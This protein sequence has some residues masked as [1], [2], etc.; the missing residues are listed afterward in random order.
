MKN[1]S[2]I[3]A[4]L[5][6]L[7]LTACGNNGTDKEKLK[8]ELKEEPKKEMQVESNNAQNQET[9]TSDFEWEGT[10]KYKDQTVT[11]KPD[12]AIESTGDFPYNR[13]M[14]QEKNNCGIDIIGLVYMGIV[15]FHYKRKGN[16]IELYHMEM[17]DCKVKELF[18]ILEKQ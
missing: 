14:V 16:K 5:L 10:Y 18:A 3:T 4:L 6:L 11:F 15:E 17:S 12:G 8:E 13:Y 9:N 1:V 7:L 2:F